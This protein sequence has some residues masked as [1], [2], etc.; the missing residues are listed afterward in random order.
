M[1]RRLISYSLPNAQIFTT[2]TVYT[3]RIRS[4]DDWDYLNERGGA[5]LGSPDS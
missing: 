2:Y 4:K 3:T 5:S 1:A